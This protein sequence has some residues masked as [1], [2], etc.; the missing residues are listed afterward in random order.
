MEIEDQLVASAQLSDSAL[1]TR[2]Y[3]LPRIVFP[4]LITRVRNS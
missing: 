2:L 4:R 1:L 3:A